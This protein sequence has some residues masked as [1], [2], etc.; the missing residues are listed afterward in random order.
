M[1]ALGNCI[2][3]LG[4]PQKRAAK[5]HVPYR[6]SK[7]TRLLQSALGGNSRT[8]MIACVSPADSSLDE[9]MCTLRY[10]HR[11]RNI[12]NKAV[13]NVDPNKAEIK[14][15]ETQVMTLQQL[16]IEQRRGFNTEIM[17]QTKDWIQGVMNHT[18]RVIGELEV[19]RHRT[20][21]K[22]PLTNLTQEE[23]SIRDQAIQDF[24]KSIGSMPLEEHQDN[25]MD[26]TKMEETKLEE[27]TTKIEETNI[28]D[29][30]TR[31][32][33]SELLTLTAEIAKMSVASSEIKGTIKK[34]IVDVSRALREK[35]MILK[36]TLISRS[37]SILEPHT[38]SLTDSLKQTNTHTYTYIQVRK[39]VRDVWK[40]LKTSVLRRLVHSQK[41]SNMLRRRNVMWREN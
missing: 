19:L 4:D 22:E 30:T 40:R 8:C 2:S 9:T 26:S 33:D 1:L 13:L 37:F 5:V 38:F 36:R 6:D 14:R 10:A 20:S 17:N 27:N 15:L 39:N 12:Q 23:T 32:D 7:L 31:Q 18:K 35:E 41:N 28:E 11:A 3:A 34:K 25:E 29:M 24:E 21:M 16:L